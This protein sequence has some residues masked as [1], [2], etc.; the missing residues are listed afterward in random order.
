M[1]HLND[2]VEYDRQQ[3]EQLHHEQT[4]LKEGRFGEMY[5]NEERICIECDTAYPQ[6]NICPNCGSKS[7]AHY[8]PTPEQIQ[9]AKDE[10]KQKDIAKRTSLNTTPYWKD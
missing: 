6:G 2:P 10:I 3:T 7:W 8:M 9:L 5:V 1:T 4:M